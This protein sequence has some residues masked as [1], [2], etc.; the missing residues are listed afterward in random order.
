[1]RLSLQAVRTHLVHGT[2]QYLYVI[3][4]PLY[5][6]RRFTREFTLQV[7]GFTFLHLLISQRLSK[8]RLRYS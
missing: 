7:N 5:L 1:M 6:R 2:G 8:L 3:A 4:H